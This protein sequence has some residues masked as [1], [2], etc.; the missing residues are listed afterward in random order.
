M[1][2]DHTKQGWKQGQ[3]S[4]QT[5]IYSVLYKQTATTG[6]VS[7]CIPIDHPYQEVEYMPISETTN[8]ITSMII[9][10]EAIYRVQH[11]DNPINTQKN[12][13]HHLIELPDCLF[14]CLFD[15]AV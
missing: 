11:A 1:S 12:V 14:H 3:N 2:V 8:Y 7:A 13:Q 15:C 6:T 4:N 9:L 5:V 10:K